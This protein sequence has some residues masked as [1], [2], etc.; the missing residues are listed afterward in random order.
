M[1]EQRNI[2]DEGPVKER[3]AKD[4]WSRDRDV[5]DFK[6]VMSTVQGRRFI[7]RVLHDVC[8][9]HRTCFHG[10][11]TNDAF[12]DLGQRNV[13]LFVLSE[14]EEACPEKGLLMNAENIEMKRKES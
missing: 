6:V 8:G 2:A 7:R 12:F 4:K 1:A 11:S 14:I 5:E 3:A 13:G 9:V 10:P